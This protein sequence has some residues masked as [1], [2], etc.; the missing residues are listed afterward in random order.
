MSIVS[1][2]EGEASEYPSS[3]RSTLESNPEVMHR[4]RLPSLQLG[5]SDTRHDSKAFGEKDDEE[6]SVV[7]RSTVRRSSEGLP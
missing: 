2:E 5:L 3:Q 1:S 7:P 6:L 4:G